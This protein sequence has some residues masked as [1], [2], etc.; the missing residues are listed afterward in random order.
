MEITL[1]SSD[2]LVA[3]SSWLAGICLAHILILIYE[4]FG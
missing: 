3:I 2:W 4:K 1:T